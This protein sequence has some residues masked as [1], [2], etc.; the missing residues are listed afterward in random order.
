VV[1]ESSGT[2][3]LSITGDEPFFGFLLP[4]RLPLKERGSGE[5]QISRALREDRPWVLFWNLIEVIDQLYSKN[6]CMTDKDGFKLRE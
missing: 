1:S 3:T 6:R 2:W 4:P 5:E